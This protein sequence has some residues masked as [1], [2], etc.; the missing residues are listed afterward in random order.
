MLLYRLGFMLNLNERLNYRPCGYMPLATSQAAIHIHVYLGSYKMHVY[1]F[2]ICCEDLEG[3]KNIS[4]LPAYEFLSFSQ[5]GHN[6]LDPSPSIT[7]F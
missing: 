6:D 1:I 5:K 4:L 3:I 2:T 7:K